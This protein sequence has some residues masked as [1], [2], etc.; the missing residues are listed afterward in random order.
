MKTNWE[1]SWIVIVKNWGRKNES[2][3]IIHKFFTDK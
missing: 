2:D 3:K 1:G